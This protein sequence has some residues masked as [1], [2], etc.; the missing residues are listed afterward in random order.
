MGER[1]E[2]L[3]VEDFSLG[4]GLALAAKGGPQIAGRDDFAAGHFRQDF[5]RSRPL[6]RRAQGEDGVENA[7]E[8]VDVGALVEIAEMTR[9][10]L[11][12]HV[13]RGAEH[14]AVPGQSGGEAVGFGRGGVLDGRVFGIRASQSRESP[15]HHHD[16]AVLADHD[17]LGFEVAMEYAF[18]V[19]EGDGV[20]DL[21]EDVEQL[22][23]GK[24]AQDL[25][26]FV[27]E[28][29]EDGAEG[30]ALEELHR[31]EERQAVLPDDVVDG[32]DVR[33]GQQGEHL[34]L[35]DET[36]AHDFVG[37]PLQQHDLDGNGASEFRVLRRQ[38][39]AHAAGGDLGSQPIVLH[40]R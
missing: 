34:G 32:H 16:L 22:G 40:A 13:L 9:R 4:E 26:D 19:G 24:V 15:V 5:L 38:H 14:G 7:A 31:V 20:A 29:F 18:A 27:A 37:V 23:Q 17:V 6:D 11:R 39:A 12:G 8:R 10:L 1:L 25:G 21:A 30:A 3:G 35:A 2:L 28:V 33:V 36:P